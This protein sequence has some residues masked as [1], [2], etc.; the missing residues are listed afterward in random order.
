MTEQPHFDV[1][2]IGGGPAGVAA[3]V[4]ADAK[5][6]SVLLIDEQERAGG[7]VYRW[8]GV[9]IDAGPGAEMR[10][11]LAASGVR[12]AFSHRCWHVQPDRT[13]RCTGP[14]GNMTFTAD[15]LI[16]ATGASERVTPVPGWT[17]PGVVGLA[18]ATILLKS[19]GVLPGRNVVVAGCGPLLLFVA[20]K[21]IAGGGQ[22]AAIVD[23]NGPSDWL[24]CLPA[25]M[26]NPKL[27]M[28]GAGWAL[29]LLK[30]GT[31]I[32]FNSRIVAVNG[33][34][35]VQA[36]SVAAVGENAS[37]SAHSIAC[38]ALCY[39]DGL[40]PATEMTRLLHADHD[41]DAAL[42]GW[43]VRADAH[44]RTSLDRIYACGDGAGVMG[45]AAAP[46][47]GRIAALAAAWDLGKMDEARFEAE[48]QRLSRY[49]QRVSRFGAAMTGLTVAGVR[50]P[51]TGSEMICRCESVSHDELERAVAAGAVTVN[52]VKAATRCGMG[53]CGGRYCVPSVAKI[54][55][56]HEQVDVSR[57]APGTAR[58]PLR[59][60]PVGTL[61]GD[62]AYEDIPFREPAPL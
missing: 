37:S 29:S 5:R 40:M 23:R 35:E 6:L 9:G 49:G 39:G 57:I 24:S 22:V 16:L 38:D 61:M 13:V 48:T 55:A 28:E 20:A 59:P 46:V 8:N 4:Q 53:P 42:G 34:D 14:D 12:T 56:A 43:H 54:I 7:Q 58:P 10:A 50:V 62:F 47:Q 44:R 60:V 25:A 15:A 52:A 1:I 26:T 19:E 17:T 31:P 18:A 3:A 51:L 30:R 27:G 21:I 36:V 2:V 33:D 32:H 11:R 41:F 45:A